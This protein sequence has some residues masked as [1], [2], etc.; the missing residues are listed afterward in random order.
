MY[1]VLRPNYNTKSFPATTSLELQFNP[2]V[3]FN[4]NSNMLSSDGTKL[5]APEEGIYSFQMMPYS[6]SINSSLISNSIIEGYNENNEFLYHHQDTLPNYGD[7]NR[8][9]SSVLNGYLPKNGY[10]KVFLW[11]NKA[12]TT[13]FNINDYHTDKSEFLRRYCIFC[14]IA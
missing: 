12:V 13:Y 3:Y 11:F 6:V 9:N 1:A 8:F 10:I 2:N 14:R 5:I 4:S 7:Y